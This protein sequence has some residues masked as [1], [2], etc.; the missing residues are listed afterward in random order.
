MAETKSESRLRRWLSPEPL[1]QSP[2][3]VTTMASRGMQVPTYAYALNNPM[4][5]VD[6][7]GLD[8]INNN[9]RP[10][11]VKPEDGPWGMLPAHSRWPGSP[12]GVIGP[13]GDVLAVS[14]KPWLPDNEVTIWPDGKPRC[15][16]GACFLLPSK[17]WPGF[18]PDWQPGENEPLLPGTSPCK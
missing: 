6:P 12:D 7:N 4:T 17:P 9:D 16:G 11:W 5:Y 2:A 18:R 8:V 15:T 14:G 3:Y 1:S 10:V 13:D